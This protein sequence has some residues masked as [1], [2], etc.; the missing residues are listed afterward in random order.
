MRYIGD[1][2]T[3]QI[4]VIVRYTW[5]TEKLSSKHLYA[6]AFLPR[7]RNSWITAKRTVLFG[8][9][10][11]R[12]IWRAWPLSN[13]NSRS[14]DRDLVRW[15]AW[16]ILSFYISSFYD[17]FYLLASQLLKNRK[18]NIVFLFKLAIEIKTDYCAVF[19]HTVSRNIALFYRVSY[20][21]QVYVKC[22]LCMC[23]C[24]YYG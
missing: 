13:Y 16:K 24:V 22:N 5:V 21:F 1:R 23:V 10:K 8:L 18:T 11:P 3:L 6:L 20:I 7:I 14:R 15:N 9:E 19:D 4:R 2:E 12:R 17:W